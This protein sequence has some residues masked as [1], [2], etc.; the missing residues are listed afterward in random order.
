MLFCLALARGLENRRSWVAVVC[1]GIA[2]IVYCDIFV[3]VSYVP[4][5]V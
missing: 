3:C 5:G 2:G 1:S 4:K